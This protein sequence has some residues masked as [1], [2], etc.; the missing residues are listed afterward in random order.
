MSSC[1]TSGSS[2]NWRFGCWP[3]C[4]LSL[5]RACAQYPGQVTKT[6]KEARTALRRRAGVYW[7]PGKP[8]GSRLVPV[9]VLDDGQLEDGGIY[10]ARPEPLALTGEVEYELE[11]DGKPIGLS[12]FA[13]A[14][15]EQG[16]WVGYGTWRPLPGP[17]PR[18]SQRQLARMRIDEDDANSDEPVLHRKHHAD[19]RASSGT[20]GSS[21][22]GNSGSDNSGSD[23]SGS[24]GQ[25]QAS[26]SDSDRTSIRTPVL[27]RAHQQ[28]A[29]EYKRLDKFR[30]LGPDSVQSDIIR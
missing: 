27:H 28:T 21:G 17:K 11:Q 29:A 23:N 2:N 19:E 25:S 4:C 8:N 26:D 14:S 1:K 5:C 18:P 9:A 6:G 20:R 24:A 12:T 10:L 3:H 22:S 16:T 15:Q 13:N 7:R 30:R